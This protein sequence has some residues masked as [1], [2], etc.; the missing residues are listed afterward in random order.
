MLI[1][2][3]ALNFMF[4]CKEKLQLCRPNYPHIHAFTLSHA[5]SPKA[6]LGLSSF[7]S[8]IEAFASIILQ[9]FSL[10][11]ST[12]AWVLNLYSLVISILVSFRHTYICTSQ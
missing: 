6:L 12:W 10:P 4:V 5:L 3:V 9:A 7:F 1:L 11:L 8:S 2:N